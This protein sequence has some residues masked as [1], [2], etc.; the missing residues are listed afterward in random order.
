MAQEIMEFNYLPI[1]RVIYGKGV[2]ERAGKIIHDYSIGKVMIITSSSVS[3]TNAF[4]KVINNIDIDYVIGNYIRE[5]SPISDIEIAVD[6]MRRE[7][8]T[9]IISMGGGSV[10]DAAKMIRYEYNVEIPQIAIPTTLSASEFSH[11]AGYSVGGIKN[12]VRDKAITPKAILIDPESARETP[13]RLWRSTGIRAIDHAVET[14]IHETISDIGKMA[15]LKAI[16]LLYNNIEYTTD[17]ARLKCF[18]GAWYSYLQVYDSPMG[19]SH[20]IGKVIGARFSIPHGITSCITLPETMKF[21]GKFFPEKM[22]EIAEAIDG[23]KAEKHQADDAAY[24]IQ[25]LLKDLGLYETMSKY[26]IKMEDAEGIFRELR[27]REPW[28]LDLIKELV[29]KK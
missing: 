13:E 10:I 1:D 29:N 11:I 6:T 27:E 5:H 15:A 9:G 20:N 28:H 14:Y 12:G 19:V 25:G 16:S 21:Y 18:I 7:K 22:K 24:L 26:G 4:R 2:L 8:C 23:V 3:K 17:E